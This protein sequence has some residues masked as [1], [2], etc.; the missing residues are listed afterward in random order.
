M[1]YKMMNGRLCVSVE[2][3]DGEFNDNDID[4]ISFQAKRRTDFMELAVYVLIKEVGSK[5]PG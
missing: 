1:I 4:R 2:D 5:W 3:C